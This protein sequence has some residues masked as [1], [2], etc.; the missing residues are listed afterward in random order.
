[1]TDTEMHKK[2]QDNMRDRV[3]GEE[4]AHFKRKKKR[5]CET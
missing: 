4:N 5:P 1:M 3:K 2:G